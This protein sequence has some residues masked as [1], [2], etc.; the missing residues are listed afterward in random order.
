MLRVLLSVDAPE[1][2]VALPEL[3]MVPHLQGGAKA[4]PG[5]ATKCRARAVPATEGTRSACPLS[6]LVAPVVV[7]MVTNGRVEWSSEGC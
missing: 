6:Q 3:S 2:G 5:R 4:V 1:D 7:M